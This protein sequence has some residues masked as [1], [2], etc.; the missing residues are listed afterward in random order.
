MALNMASSF[1]ITGWRTYFLWGMLVA[2]G[3]ARVC[4]IYADRLPALLIVMLH[5]V[6]PALFALAHGSVLYRVKGIMVFAVLCL[7]FGTLAES[8]SLRTGFPFGHYYFTDVMG[9]KIVQLPVLLALAYLGIGYVAWTLALVIL[10]YVDRPIHGMGV[11]ALPLLASFIMV[12]WDLSMD[13]TWSTLDHAWIWKE[14]GAYFGVPVSNFFGWFLTGYLYYQAFALYCRANPISA[15]PSRQRF[16]LPAI[17]IYAVCALG[18]TLLLELPMAPS[19][20]TDAAGQQWLTA[21]ILRCCLLVSLL[22]MAPLSLL[23]WLKARERPAKVLHVSAG[24]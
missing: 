12:A 1:G 4:L 11:L 19:V 16:W 15:P 23:A 5:V 8:V 3:M 20:V 22:V 24:S 17:L 9:P 14:G 13:P 6:P 10:G 18:N 2:Y 21:D 7:G